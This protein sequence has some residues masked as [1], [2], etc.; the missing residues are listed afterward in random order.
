MF[1]I[2]RSRKGRAS[3]FHNQPHVVGDW[4]YRCGRTMV[5]V[6]HTMIDQRTDVE[7]MAGCKN[8]C[9][10]WHRRGRLMER[11]LSWYKMQ[12][13]NHVGTFIGAYHKDSIYVPT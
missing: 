7:G 10:S 2:G 13:E 5:Y 12:V 3:S 9:L 6:H 4:Y 11:T 1:L 8:T